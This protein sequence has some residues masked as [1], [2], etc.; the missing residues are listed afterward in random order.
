MTKLIFE[1]SKAGRV[2]ANV[3]TCEDEP[4]KPTSEYLPNDF[5]RNEKVSLPEV[6][7]LE[8]IRHFTELAGK[9]FSIDKG[10]YPLGS[11]TMKYNPKINELVSRNERFANLHPKAPENQTQGALDLM[12]ILGLYLK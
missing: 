4:Q 1:K 8:L 5:I 12:F 7:E 11:C 3:P 10:F 2:C 6:S 9:N